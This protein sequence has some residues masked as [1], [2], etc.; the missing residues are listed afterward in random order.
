M[1]ASTLYDL[2]KHSLFTHGSYHTAA[3]ALIR[4]PDDIQVSN[5]APWN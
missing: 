4:K 3:A 5:L 2:S 1:V